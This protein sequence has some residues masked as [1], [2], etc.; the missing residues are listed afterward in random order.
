LHAWLIRWPVWLRLN[1]FAQ[2]TESS[3]SMAVIV[4]RELW[5]RFLQEL[6]NLALSAIN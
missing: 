1:H 3:T 2:D 4:N 6:L 5:L